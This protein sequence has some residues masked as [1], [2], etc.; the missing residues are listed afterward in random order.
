MSI[1]E[2]GGA[3]SIFM[4]WSYRIARIAGIDVRI[5]LS[6]LLLPVIFGFL[7]WRDGGPAAAGNALG[8]LF[9]GESVTS[10]GSYTVRAGGRPSDATVS[11]S[12][13]R[14]R[15]PSGPSGSSPANDR[16]PRRAA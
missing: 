11:C 9:R 4:K 14:T 13:P 16:T 6:F 7:S 10:P 3:E 8:M 2:A 5:H 1:G 15:T 12:A